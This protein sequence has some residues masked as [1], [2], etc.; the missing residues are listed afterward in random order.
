MGDMCV[1]GHRTAVAGK[2]RFGLVLH[3]GARWW[4]VPWW[5]GSWRWGIE[6]WCRYDS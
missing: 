1:L 3:N 6:G 4:S 5:D 2:C